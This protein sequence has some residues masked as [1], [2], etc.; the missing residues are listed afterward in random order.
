MKRIL[1]IGSVGLALATAAP[2]VPAATLLQS[3]SVNASDA[4]GLAPFVDAYRNALGPLNAFDPV[5]GDPN[6]RRQ[7][8]WDAAPDAVSDPNAFPGDFFN[9]NVNPRARGI[10][11]QETGATASFLLSATVASGQPPRFGFPDV[12]VF[13]EERL[14]APVDGTTLDVRFFDPSD[15]TTPAGSRGLGVVFS[16]VNVAGLTLLTL[17]DRHDN[18]LATQAA[19]ANPAGPSLSFVGFIFDDPTIARASINVGDAALLGNGSVGAGTD[20]VF[21][22]DFIF[23]EP[24]TVVPLPPAVLLLA[25]AVVGLIGVGRLRRKHA[26]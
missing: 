4:A 1:F 21:M 20:S 22:D 24:T 15:Q 26:A 10:V 19:L 5:N 23:G 18:V 14:F 17:F 8:D 3:I 11:F 16:D 9:F 6:G 13:S 2:G 25:S 7:V 12:E